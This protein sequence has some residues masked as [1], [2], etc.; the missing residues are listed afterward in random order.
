MTCMQ[1]SRLEIL[2]VYYYRVAANAVLSAVS[3]RTDSCTTI[4]RGGVELFG[5]QVRRTTSIMEGDLSIVGF[6]ASTR[7]LWLIKRVVVACSF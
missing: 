3:W 4:R 1:P 2:L 5:L 6:T 7:R